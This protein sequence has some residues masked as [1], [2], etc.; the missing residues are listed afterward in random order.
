[1]NAPTYTGEV[2]VG[3]TSPTLMRVLFD[4]GSDWF[5]IASSECDECGRGAT[6]DNALSATKIVEKYSP[7][8]LAY[9]SAAMK[10]GVWSDTVCLSAQKA[11]CVDDFKYFSFWS[12][13]GLQGSTDG[14][15]GLA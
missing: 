8:E 12:Q 2:R 1:M 5:A 9:G 3:S 4:T 13:T 11:S 15:M 14:I 7:E 6:R 10:G